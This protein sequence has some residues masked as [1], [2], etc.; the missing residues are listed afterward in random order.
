[1][2]K[3]KNNLIIKTISKMKEIVK[4]DVEQNDEIVTKQFKIDEVIFDGLY[5]THTKKY[6][7]YNIKSFGITKQQAKTEKDIGIKYSTQTG[8]VI[9]TFNVRQQGYN[10]YG[11]FLIAKDVKPLDILDC[12]H[13]ALE[14]MKEILLD[15][16]D[17]AKCVTV[18]DLLKLERFK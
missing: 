10:F 11:Q 1:M 8:C 5:M 18:A 12:D 6:V 14:G 2:N 15:G 13:V 16:L 3:Y 7:K 17:L 9:V 4:I